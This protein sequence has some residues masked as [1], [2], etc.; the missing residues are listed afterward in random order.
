M[1]DV[2]AKAWAGAGG[3][4]DAGKPQQVASRSN[5]DKKGSTASPSVLRE[6]LYKAI[7]EAERWLS[8]TTPGDGYSYKTTHAI[9]F[10]HYPELQVPFG[11]GCSE[12]VSILVSAITNMA[13]EVGFFDSYTGV[14][15][16]RSWVDTLEGVIKGWKVKGDNSPGDR[17]CEAIVQGV[18]HR[19]DTTLLCKDIAPRVQTV[20][21]LKNVALAVYGSKSAETKSSD[22]LW[23]S[24]L[25]SM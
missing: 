25:I 11:C 12:E 15:V 1:F 4:G 9:L 3:V 16:M 7:Q 14:V 23:G 2:L 8:T 6:D 21:I 19:S 20:G 17:I 13:M 22:A 24:K 5:K 18:N 10:P